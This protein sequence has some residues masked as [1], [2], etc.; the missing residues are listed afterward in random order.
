MNGKFIVKPKPAIEL[1]KL[2]RVCWCVGVILLRFIGDKVYLF[3]LFL[4]FV[5]KN[6][7]SHDH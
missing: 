2:C 6:V 4:R 1:N 3:L 5:D 7:S